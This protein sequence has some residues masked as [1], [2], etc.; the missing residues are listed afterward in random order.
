MIR[1][2][3]LLRSMV[4]GYWLGAGVLWLLGLSFQYF[5]NE[6]TGWWGVVVVKVT[7]T[8]KVSMMTLQGHVYVRNDIS[9]LKKYFLQIN[10]TP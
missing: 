8:D 7:I 10:F 6:G 9:F 5:Q 2:F 3:R 1:Q 4:N